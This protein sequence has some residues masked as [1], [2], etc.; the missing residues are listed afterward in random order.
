MNMADSRPTFRVAV[1]VGG[2]FTDVVAVDE[3]GQVTFAKAPSTPAD[4]SDGVL[5]ALSRLAE[6]LGRRCPTSSAEPSRS[7]TA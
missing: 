3:S 2:T 5:A 4:Q 7:S 1:D 6:T